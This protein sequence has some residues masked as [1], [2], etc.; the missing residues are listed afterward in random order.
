MEE[1]EKHS[2]KKAE[3]IIRNYNGSFR[4]IGYTV[5]RISKGEAKG[6]ASNVSYCVE[7]FKEV[8]PSTVVLDKVYVTIMDCDGMAPKEYIDEVNAAIYNNPEKSFKTLFCPSKFMQLNRKNIILPIRS[9]DDY[10]SMLQ[11]GLEIPGADMALAV[12]NYTVSYKAVESMGFWDKHA[13]AIT[14]DIHIGL[15][16]FFSRN[17]DFY[18]QQIQVPFN[19][20]NIEDN[21]GYLSNLNLKFW[22][23]VRHAY[24]L[25]EG[26][27]VLDQFLHQKQKTPRSWA[28]LVFM[29]NLLYF[30]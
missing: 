3:S 23:T 12:S 15:K 19:E 24:I 4:H 26:G 17:E 28:V 16:G 7:R 21:K 8:M 27:Y 25:K 5:H 22:Q 18:A 6:K 2:E 30:S 11:W 9:L 20:L 14:E 13:D 29:L 10:Q 1:H